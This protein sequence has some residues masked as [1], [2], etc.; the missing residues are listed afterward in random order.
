[1]REENELVGL[2]VLGSRPVRWQVGI[3]GR[4]DG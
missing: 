1:M 2:N 4:A 3:R